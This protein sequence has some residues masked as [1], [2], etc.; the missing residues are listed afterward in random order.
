[1]TDRA[2]EQSLFPENR[3]DRPTGPI[4]GSVQGGA[5]ADLIA[6]IAPLY[7]T[8]S[9]L[10]VT[11]GEGG[12]W[13][14]FKPT[15]FTAH[16]LYKLDGIDFRALP[17]TDHS[18]DTVCFDPPY[19]PQGG[20]SSSTADTFRDRF[21]LTTESTP[22]WECFDLMA[23]GLKECARVTRQ[24]VLVKCSDFVTGGKF[25]LGS[26]HMMNTGIELGLSIHDLI[27]HH[28]GSGPGGHNIFTPLRARRHHSY[29][30]VFKASS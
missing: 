29:L 14:R 30:I 20:M 22:W 9:V 5:N 21:G 17:E 16:D 24:W 2:V 18:I 13:K 7:L 27:V 15:E 11:Y 6:A 19:V 1:M 8:G 10:D 26:L 12:W 28:T 3:P 25:T 4:L 23:T